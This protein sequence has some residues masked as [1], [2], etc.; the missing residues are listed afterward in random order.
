MKNDLTNPE[1]KL[2][3]DRLERIALSSTPASENNV[4]GRSNC[5]QIKL[6]QPS[7]SSL[8]DLILNKACCRAPVTILKPDR[9]RFLEEITKQIKPAEK[10]TLVMDSLVLNSASSFVV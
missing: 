5:W 9:A 6:Y 10:I 3:N 1:R 8:N 4:R 7:Q 2:E